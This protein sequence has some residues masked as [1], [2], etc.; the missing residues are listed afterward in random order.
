MHDRSVRVP[1][2]LFVFLVHMAALLAV[3]SVVWI[4][5]PYAGQRVSVGAGIV[6]WL[7]VLSLAGIA[8]YEPEQ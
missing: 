4:V 8:T 5:E 3:A 2:A 1:P 6:A 7:V